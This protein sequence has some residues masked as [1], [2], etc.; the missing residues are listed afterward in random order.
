MNAQPL[1]INRVPTPYPVI[2]APVPSPK[3]SESKR[4]GAKRSGSKRSDAKRSG[5]KRSGA[6]RSHPKRSGAKRSHTKRS[7]AKRSHTKRSGAK[8]SHT[9]RSGAKRSGAKRSGAKRSGA[10]RSGSKRTHTKR[11]GAKRSGAKRSG[12][13]RSHTKRSHTKRS[14]AKNIYSVENMMRYFYEMTVKN[15]SNEHKASINIDKSKGMMYGTASRDELI[16]MPWMYCVKPL[17]SVAPGPYTFRINFEGGKNG[18]KIKKTL[19]IYNG[20]VNLFPNS[21]VILNDILSKC[22]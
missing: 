4:S 8:R 5:A 11:S 2:V 13:K 22:N 10:K 20:T 14:G 1:L 15:L 6:K 16:K 17:W 19:S 7:G 3:R 12:A 18:E 9:K 21:S